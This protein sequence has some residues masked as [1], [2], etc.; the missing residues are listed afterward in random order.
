MQNAEDYILVSCDFNSKYTNASGQ[1]TAGVLEIKG[2]FVQDSINYAFVASGTHKTVF[3]GEEAQTVTL[4]CLSSALNIIEITNTSESG[5]DFT[6]AVRY[7]EL[8]DEN[9]KAHFNEAAQLNRTLT[10]NETIQGDFSFT[11]GELNLSGFTLTVNGDL[12]H[13]GGTINI[14]SGKLVV[15]GD[16]RVETPNEDGSFSQSKGILKMSD[17]TGLVDVNGGFIYNSVYYSYSNITAGTIQ[18]DGNVKLTNFSIYGSANHTF[19][20][21][22]TAKQTI[23]GSGIYFD[24]F[25]INNTSSEGIGISTAVYVR[26][27]LYNTDTPISNSSKIYLYGGTVDGGVW[28]YDLTLNSS[29]SYGN[30]HIKGDVYGYI[31]MTNPDDYLIIDGDINFSSSSTLTNGV[32]EVKGD[33]LQGSSTYLT[34]IASN[35]HKTIL[36][37]DKLQTVNISNANSAFNILEIKNYSD[38]GVVFTKNVKIG[39]LITNDCKVNIPETE[40][41]TNIIE[42]NLTLDKD[43]VITGDLYLNAGTLNLNGF[44]LTVTGNIIHSGGTMNINGGMLNVNGSYRLQSEKLNTY[45]SSTGI[46][47]MQNASDTINIT[48]SFIVQSTVQS[49]LTAGTLNIGGNIEQ[50]YGYQYS[51]TASGSHTTVLNGSSVQSISIYYPT[52]SI[53]RNLAIENSSEAGVT[54]QTN[55]YV[56]GEFTDN[57]YK[58]KNPNYLVI[59]GGIYN[60]TE[61]N[62]H[63]TVTSNFTLG[64]DLTIKG[65]LIVNGGTLN[66]NGH[67]LTVTG[68]YTQSSG[69]LTLGGD[70]TVEGNASITQGVLSLNGHKLTING[71]LTNNT[72]KV[73]NSSSRIYTYYSGYIKMTDTDD[74][75]FVGGNF[76]AITIN[77]TQNYYTAGTLEVKGNFTQGYYTSYGSNKYGFYASG[78]HRVIL[79][80]EALQTVRFDNTESKFC[81]L[82]IKNT[83]DDGVVFSTPVNYSRI[84]TNDNKVAFYNN[85]RSGWTLTGDEII[86]TD[87]N[88]GS[89]VL[90]L[91]GHTLTIN[92]SLNQY[93]GKVNINGGKLIINGDYLIQNLFETSNTVSSGIL[94]MI[95]PADVVSVS[96]DFV[97]HSSVSHKYYLTAGTLEIGGDFIEKSGGSTSDF[98]ASGTHKVV[99]NG[100]TAQTVNLTNYSNCAINSLTLQNTS[101]EGITFANTVYVTGELINDNS[102]LNSSE[103]IYIASSAS[104]PDSEWKDNLTIA[105]RTDFPGVFVLE[106]PLTIDGT[107]T[108][109]G[110]FTTNK[111]LVVNGNLNYYDGNTTVNDGIY[112][113]GDTKISS[114]SQGNQVFKLNSEMNIDGN[115]DI[116][117]G[118]LFV[119][120]QTLNIGGNLSIGYKTENSDYFSFGYLKMTNGSDRVFVSGDFNMY[121]YVGSNGFLTNGVLD[122][123]GDFLQY[124]NDNATSGFYATGNHRTILS[125]DRLQNVV[126]DSAKSKFNILEIKNYSEDGVLINNSISYSELITNGCKVTYSGDERIG[127]KLTSNEII[128]GDLNL[129]AGTLDLNGFTLTVTG[130]LI[131]SGGTIYVNGGTLDIAGDFRIQK[132]TGESFGT[133][134]GILKM[135]NPDDTLEIGGGFTTQSQESHEGYLTAGKMYVAGDF[136]QLSPSSNGGNRNPDYDHSFYPT[137]S[138]TVILNGTETQNVSLYFSNSYR[139]RSNGDYDYFARFENLSIENTSTTGVNFSKALRVYGEISNRSSKLQNLSN[140]YFTSSTAVAGGSWADDL[141]INDNMTLGSDLEVTG[142]LYLNDNMNLNAHTLSVCG[143]V[144]HKSGT[145]TIGRGKLYIDGNYENNYSQNGSNGITSMV[146]ID[147]YMLV[148]G[149]YYLQTYYNNNSFTAGILEIRGNVDFRY[150]NSSYANPFTASGSHKTLLSGENVQSVYI[151]GTSSTFNVLEITKDFDTGYSFTNLRYNELIEA[152]PDIELPIIRSISVPKKYITGYTSVSVS[153]SDNSSVKSITLQY[154][155][156]GEVWTDYTTVDNINR[157]S[158]SKDFAFQNTIDGTYFIRAVTAD[159]KGNISDVDISPYETVI[160]DKVKPETPYD[161]TSDVT[162]GRIKVAW[163]YDTE[164]NDTAYFRVY[165]KTAA[166]SYTLYKDN[167]TYTDLSDFSF[168]TGITYTYKIAAVDLSGNESIHSAEV[169]EIIISDY[170]PPEI[171]SV[172]PKTG[173]VL[174]ASDELSISC[175]DNLS[176]KTLTVTY[177]KSSDSDWLPLKEIS[178]D[179]Y[180]KI[181]DVDID[182]TSFEN[183]LYEFKIVLIDTY[184]NTSNEKIITYEFNKGSLSK[185]GVTAEGK[186]YRVELTWDMD[187]TANLLGY[188]IYKKSPG[189]NA[190]SILASTTSSNYADGYVTPGLTY[191]YKIEA[192]DS[193]ENAVMSDIVNVVPTNEDDVAPIADAGND[194]IGIVGKALS[195]DGSDSRDNHNAIDKYE[196]DF[197]DGES[198]TGSAVSHEYE[199]S[200]TYTAILTVTDSAGNSSTDTIT[201]LIYSNDYFELTISTVDENGRAIDGVEIICDEIFG[202]GISIRTDSSGNVIL[203]IR[204]GSYDFIFFANGYIAKSEK[205][206]V[207]DD[208]LVTVTLEK[209]ETVSGEF[210]V[211]DK[212]M[213][214]EE[215]ISAGIDTSDPAN[216]HITKSVVKVQYDS[217]EK[218][219]TIYRNTEGELIIVGSDDAGTFEE[220]RI[221]GKLAFSSANNNISIGDGWMVIPSKSASTLYEGEEIEHIAMMRVTTEVAFAKEFYKAEIMIINNADSNLTITEANVTLNLPNGL[222]VGGTGEATIDLGDISGGSFAE[223][224]W[225]V[226]GDKAGTYSGISAYFT[227]ILNSTSKRINVTFNSDQNITILGGNALRFEMVHDLWSPTNDVWQIDYKLTNISEKTVNDIK[228]DIFCDEIQNA[229][230]DRIEIYSDENMYPVVIRYEGDEFNIEEAEWWFNPLIED[231]RVTAFNLEP[232]EYIEFTVFINKTPPPED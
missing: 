15:N 231:I 70:M 133:S 17:E 164:G 4:E 142:D 143:N 211:S 5:V 51:L 220:Y 67:K 121:T 94:S 174:K 135:T 134:V 130:N 6:T 44:S 68:N 215:I 221:N 193:F 88:L 28:N 111:P 219:L 208:T 10:A 42:K 210:V 217:K 81:I 52:Y 73:Y 43:W 195:F 48:G 32:L 20:L 202:S 147:D 176:L 37:G 185:P 30:L 22:G 189:Q 23:S 105:N 194:I 97:M 119:N 180:H 8:I 150:Y 146:N 173:S 230:V 161:V 216:Q 184:D 225:I 115:L 27:T 149:N 85:M 140:L 64:T 113:K 11:G 159:S 199:K 38:D 163:K 145:L 112:V 191:V 114:S 187:N 58:L 224:T 16:Y 155:P 207:N 57:A 182:R 103:K 96:G 71:S 107:L 56:S 14:G 158:V 190:F 108:I 196:W 35:N 170:T 137:G 76:S 213:S 157:S 223:A 50:L 160:I 53:L 166:T 205:I 165:R 226:R 127:W 178:L 39:E 169:S 101:A 1:I 152:T 229:N 40:E 74:Y 128:D 65:N 36:S 90:N 2:D 93:A 29:V 188:N 87:L 124:T 172:S 100:D 3:S 201:V 214:F 41:E 192:I 79:S 63:L 19:E 21:T 62:G 84:I 86:D 45:T 25:K 171:L 106:K 89:G 218:Q 72:S 122:I 179:S 92:G 204:K 31:Y 95:K 200:G 54:F 102:I 66:Q 136:T 55:V 120:G 61:Y 60:P 47:Q 46:L 206:T 222:S 33:I 212:E 141:Y 175:Y 227:G 228:I 75:L 26:G 167:Y 7:S 186:G 151:Q 117:G 9:D 99:L 148:G 138:H 144:I 104:L 98:F 82:E 34:F 18:V 153:A 154:S 13:S 69:N 198:G 118:I 109:Y 59:S 181:I 80:G 83:S 116:N 110:D 156:D 125:G 91:N 131:Q 49:Y 209:G 129:T 132:K 162:G 126:F 24:D 183:G 197:G 12:I 203:P 232:N 177:K 77:N 139:Y 123:K 168:N 78:T